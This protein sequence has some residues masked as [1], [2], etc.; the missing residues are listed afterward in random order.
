MDKEFTVSDVL[1]IIKSQ[2]ETIPVTGQN[3]RTMA[4]VFN[5]ID[6]LLDACA[7]SKKDEEAD[8]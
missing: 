6:I 7:V 5:N 2:L 1:Q 3:V 8:N 4:G